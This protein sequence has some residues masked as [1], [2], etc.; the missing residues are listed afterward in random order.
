M[1]NEFYVYAN[2]L[3]ILQI[4]RVKQ[5]FFSFCFFNS[6]KHCAYAAVT[7]R[8][9]DTHMLL[10]TDQ[11]VCF[12]VKLST[13][14]FISYNFFSWQPFMCP[15]CP[16]AFRQQQ[17]LRRHIKLIHTNYVPPK[18]LEKEHI[19]P[20]CKKAFA[21]NGNLIRHLEVHDPNSNIHEIKKQ[22]KLGRAK[23]ITIDADGNVIDVE[24]KNETYDQLTNMDEQQELYGDIFNDT[25]QYEE[26]DQAFEVIYQNSEDESEH[27]TEEHNAAPLVEKVKIKK[28]K[29]CSET[30]SI[31]EGEAE[32]QGGFVVIEVIPVG[33]NE[34]QMYE[35]QL[36]KETVIKG[37]FEG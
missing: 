8:H 20:H 33:K 32:N 30:N 6:C 31:N 27:N 29:N 12:Y 34:E 35:T 9:L 28:E 11:K 14:R 21:F 23:R 1:P 36:P 19:C 4:C 18:P 17:L 22:L 16:A 26:D 2:T 15:T 25:C 5:I 10:H 13:H 3:R 37:K 24:C 7:Q